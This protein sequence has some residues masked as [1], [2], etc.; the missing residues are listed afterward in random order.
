MT[1]EIVGSLTVSR[2][3]RLVSGREGMIGP[4]LLEA[5]E[6]DG[7]SGVTR[8]ALRVRRRLS[9]DSLE[10]AR[11]AALCRY[12]QALWGQDKYLVAGLDEAGVGP[13]AG[14]VVAAA[15]ILPAGLTITGVNDSKQ[16][17]ARKREELA[18]QI[19]HNAVSWAFGE[20]SPEEIDRLNIFQASLLA[21]RRA[22]L[23]LEITPEHL[24]IDA[25]RIPGINTPQT[26]IP[27]GDA[28]SLTIAS[29]SILAKTLRD[30]LMLNL[31]RKYPGYGFARHKGYPTREHRQAILRLGPTP[32]HRRSFTLIP[33]S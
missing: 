17:S 29:A 22:I 26:S 27:K 25:R 10:R 3:A 13:L 8:L 19:R 1:P 7:R 18:E 2:L 23:N 11:L 4:E 28:V 32:E 5:L 12:E 15:V 9:A 24:L 20:S 14:P 33:G 30:E 6:E 31:D 16:L 21:M